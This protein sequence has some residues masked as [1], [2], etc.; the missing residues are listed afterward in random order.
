LSSGDIVTSFGIF[1]DVKL[2]THALQKMEEEVYVYVYWD[3][4]PPNIS[5]LRTK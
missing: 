1:L 2:K 5:I 3:T 4:Y